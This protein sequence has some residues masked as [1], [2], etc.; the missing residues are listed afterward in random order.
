MKLT[1]FINT[2]IRLNNKSSKTLTVQKNYND[3]SNKIKKLYK[4]RHTY[5]EII[6]EK[7]IVIN[8]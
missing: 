1:Y 8:N 6:L 4:T 2:G 5:I 3:Y 7:M